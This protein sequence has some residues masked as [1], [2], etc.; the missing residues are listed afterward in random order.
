[1]FLDF[2]GLLVNVFWRF[3]RFLIIP[4]WL[5]LTLG[6]IPILFGSFLELPKIRR[7]LAP[8]IPHL[9]TKNFKNT[10][11]NPKI[12]ETYYVYISGLPK[13]C[14]FVNRSAPANPEESFNEISKI[15]DIK[16]IAFKTHEWFLLIW[17]QYLLQNAKSFF[18]ILFFLIIWGLLSWVQHNRLLTRFS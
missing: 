9:S 3:F 5:I 10:R 12:F 4:K 11:E 17:Y 7:S 13:F 14:Q 18:A 8:Y 1:M 2:L 6:H 16:P 15:I